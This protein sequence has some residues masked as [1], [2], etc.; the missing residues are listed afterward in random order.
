MKLVLAAGL[1]IALAGCE[2][3][4]KGINGSQVYSLDGVKRIAPEITRGDDPT[5]YT[6]ASYAL[7]P[8]SRLL[9]RFESF[10][11]Y[12]GSINADLVDIRMRVAVV[13]PPKLV[14]ALG[15]LRLCPLIENWMML[16]T[17]THAHPFGGGR[18]ATPGGTHDEAGC[19]TAA[20]VP[21]DTRAL[22][23]DLHQ[24]FLDYARGR[25]ANYGLLLIATAPVEILGD[26]SGTY[27]PRILF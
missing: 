17:W 22:Q 9:L 11:E 2:R 21:G 5:T 4:G 19:V 8:T 26:T 27:S 16:A 12:V 1:L 15:A 25:A 20:A 10:A 6:Q 18:W 13:D 7:S 23:F 3:L 24:W 14:D